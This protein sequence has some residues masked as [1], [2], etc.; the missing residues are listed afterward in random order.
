MSKSRESFLKN[1]EVQA[2]LTILGSGYGKN[3]DISK[4]P[5]A[6]V[7]ILADAD[8]DKKTVPSDE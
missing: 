7:V 5:Y 8:P 1:E 2:I 6:K 4:C 3:F